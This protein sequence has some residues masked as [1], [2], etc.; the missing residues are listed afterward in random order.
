[1]LLCLMVKGRITSEGLLVIIK[2]NLILNEITGLNDSLS[3]KDSSCQ[4][5]SYFHIDRPIIEQT[6]I[7]NC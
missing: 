4:K 3:I 1:M 5:G 6:K 7:N 2:D